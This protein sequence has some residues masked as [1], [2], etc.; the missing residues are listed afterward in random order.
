MY[1]RNRVHDPVLN[2][3]CVSLS[4]NIQVVK[5]RAGCYVGAMF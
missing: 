3:I 5:F 2:D 1:L 4:R